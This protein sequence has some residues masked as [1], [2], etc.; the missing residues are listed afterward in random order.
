LGTVEEFYREWQDKKAL[1][2]YLREQYAFLR[3]TKRDVGK[4]LASVNKIVETVDYDENEVR[5]IED[6]ARQLAIQ[7]TTGSF[8]ERGN[9]AREL[10]MLVRH[11]TGVAKAKYVA[12][13]V[14]IL[15]ES[16]EPVVL[17]GWHRDVYDIW[18]ER[19][20]DLKPAMYTGSETPNRKAKSAEAFL[21]GETD[22]LIMSLR[23]G[24][25]IDGLQKRCSTSVVGELDW[26]PAVHEQGP[27][28]R[29]NR[30]GQ[31]SPVNVFFLVTNEGSDPPMMELLGLK[32]SIAAQI[33]DP[34]AGPQETHSD[35][36]HLQLLVQRYLT[37]KEKRV[38]VARP[39]EPEA[40]HIEARCTDS[41]QPDL[42]ERT[43]A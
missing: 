41:V 35:Q 13:F 6:L 18:L 20:A 21:R 3:R 22:I 28:G 5:S 29:L 27:I 36:S 40:P 38:A 14:R 12:D 34:L 43:A 30:E 26:S 4:E 1:G 15:V 42:F 39:D 8:V 16:G 23:S 32:S 11:H 31:T 25:G 24:A 17:F 10:D 7:A 33:V 19:L 37:G 9:A 2:T